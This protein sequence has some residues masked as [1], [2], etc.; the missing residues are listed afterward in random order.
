MKTCFFGQD[1]MEEYLGIR[2]SIFFDDDFDF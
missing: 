2:D 1:N